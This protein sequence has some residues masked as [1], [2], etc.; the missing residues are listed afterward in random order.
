MLRKPAI[1]SGRVGLGLVCTFTPFYL[2]LTFNLSRL[3]TSPLSRQSIRTS[4]A[5]LVGFVP[6]LICCVPKK[7]RKDKNNLISINYLSG[8]LKRLYQ[9]NALHFLSCNPALFP[10]T[11]GRSNSV[12]RISVASWLSYISD[13]VEKPGHGNDFA[14]CGFSKMKPCT[15]SRNLVVA[16]FLNLSAR[17]QQYEAN[18]LV[19]F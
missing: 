15:S 18:H 4:I 13:Y 5:T 14:K 3:L 1:S 9:F 11:F 17:Y 6:S 16:K 19:F 12:T 7:I 8:K 2:R 10:Q